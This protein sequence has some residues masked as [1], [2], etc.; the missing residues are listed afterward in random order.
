MKIQNLFIVF[1]ILFSISFISA[2]TY[3]GSFD[4]DVGRGS[5]IIQEECEEDWSSSF[6]SECINNQ[7]TFI[8]IQTN[9]NCYTTN[10]KPAQCGEVREC[11]IIEETTN[12]DSSS[13]STNSKSPSSS[14][15]GG[16]TVT[17]YTHTSEEEPEC[18]ENWECGKWSNTKDSCGTRICTDSN[19]CGT[20]ELKPLT[21]KKCPFK[22][23]SWI[24]GGVIN[25]GISSFAK[26]GVGI[27]LIIAILIIAAGVV[28]L[29]I[30]KK[31]K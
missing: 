5:I 21:Y 18:V 3:H 25:E 15:S 14:S 1:A 12:T 22:F 13:S 9:I 6:W 28:V 8:C 10:L 30:T 17:T 4:V 27:G 7:Q 23:F 11:G 24:T 29:F 26:S 31:K 16:G 2:A 20:T 19:A